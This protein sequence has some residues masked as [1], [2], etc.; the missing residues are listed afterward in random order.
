MDLTWFANFD[1]GIDEFSDLNSHPKS[2]QEKHSLL[3]SILHAEE[4]TSN[5]D[6][7]RFDPTDYSPTKQACISLEGDGR[8]RRG[9]PA[10]DSEGFRNLRHGIA[11]GCQSQKIG[12][13]VLA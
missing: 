2:D 13:V 1:T 3:A 6:A 7:L 11:R 12:I 9:Y 10:R 5:P 4:I 8:F